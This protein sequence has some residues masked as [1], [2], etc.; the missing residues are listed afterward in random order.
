MNDRHERTIKDGNSALTFQSH[1]PGHETNQLRFARELLHPLQ[2]YAKETKSP[3][4]HRQNHIS[5]TL[6]NFGK[7][8]LFPSS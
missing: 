6:W 4:G 8:P 2:S 5:K 3:R 7:I 1:R